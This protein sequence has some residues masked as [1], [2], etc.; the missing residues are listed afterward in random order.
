[1]QPLD[2]YYLKKGNISQL[3]VLNQ[4]K[5]VNLFITSICFALPFYIFDLSQVVVDQVPSRQV[6]IHCIIQCK[7][8]Y[9]LY[10]ILAKCISQYRHS[11]LLYTHQVYQY[12]VQ[13][14]RLETQKLKNFSIF[15]YLV[16]HKLCET[17]YDV[18]SVVYFLYLVYHKLCK[19]SY[20]VFQQYILLVVIFFIKDGCPFFKTFYFCVIKKLLVKLQFSCLYD[21]ILVLKNAVPVTVLLQN[22]FMGRSQTLEIEIAHVHVIFHNTWQLLPNTGQVIDAVICICVSFA[23][24]L[25]AIQKSPS[26]GL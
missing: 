6:Q 22:F 2:P 15:L 11:T 16:Y 20:D 25:L 5:N 7:F 10:R 14:T 1:M 18:F 4:R 3:F 8:F 17:S 24:N 9:L 26:S 13:Y 21:F 23:A 19:T 12:T